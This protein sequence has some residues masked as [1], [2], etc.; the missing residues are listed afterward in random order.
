MDGQPEGKFS[1]LK[2]MFVQLLF[3]KKAAADV[4]RSTFF[5]IFIS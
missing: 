5:D 1:T 4:F 3:T 2:L